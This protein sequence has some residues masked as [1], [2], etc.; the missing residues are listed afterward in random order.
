MFCRTV[1]TTVPSRPRG[2]GSVI[3]SR[4][5]AGDEH[6]HAHAG[7]D[8]SSHA[9]HFVDLDCDGSHASGNGGRQS[10]AGAPGA[11][12]LSRIGSP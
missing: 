10:A 11:R 6:V 2:V 1:L 7:S 9:H 3:R 4:R 8:K 5:N 12:R